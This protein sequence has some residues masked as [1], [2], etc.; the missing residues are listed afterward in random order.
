MS[1]DGPHESSSTP[2]VHMTRRI[3]PLPQVATPRDVADA[4]ERL[5]RNRHHGHPAAHARQLAQSDIEVGH[6]LEHLDGEYQVE[7]TVTE[8]ECRNIT[9][10]SCHTPPLPFAGQMLVGQ[11]DPHCLCHREALHQALQNLALPNTYF[12]DAHR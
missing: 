8:V 12:D 6:M 7:H 5:A 11:V 10:L 4:P 2:V 9:E 3:A 1:A